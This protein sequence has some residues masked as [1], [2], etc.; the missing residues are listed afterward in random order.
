MLP[1]LSYLGS[2]VEVGRGFLFLPPASYQGYQ[3]LSLNLLINCVRL[4]LPPPPACLTALWVVF[5]YS[6][7][8]KGKTGCKVNQGTEASLS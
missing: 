7:I 4:N 2:G 3:S 5:L 6:K 8:R 1:D